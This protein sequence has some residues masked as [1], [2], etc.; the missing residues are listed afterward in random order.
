MKKVYT[1]LTSALLGAAA[2]TAAPAAIDGTARISEEGAA[3]LRS[4][5]IKMD[6]AMSVPVEGI[7]TYTRAYT[8]G[9]NQYVFSMAL[10]NTQTWADVL[11]IDKGDGTDDKVTFEEFPFYVVRTTMYIINIATGEQTAYIPQ[12]LMW[13]AKYLFSQQ[14]EEIGD[15]KIPVD[16]RDLSATSP[17][18]LCNTDQYCKKFV[19]GALVNGGMNPNPPYDEATGQYKNWLIM[20]Q[21]M[22]QVVTDE[23]NISYQGNPAV[24]ICTTSRAPAI[25]FKYYLEDVNE[26]AM[27]YECYLNVKTE[28]STVGRNVRVSNFVGSTRIDGWAPRDISYPIHELH[29]FNA[30]ETSSSIMGASSPYPMPW[31]PVRRL[32]VMGFGND[33][34]EVGYKT[35]SN[36][37]NSDDLVAQY[38][39]TVPA[40]EQVNPDNQTFFTGGLYASMDAANPYYGH[41]TIATPTYAWVP[42]ISEEFG[43]QL[44]MIPAPGVAIPAFQL[45]DEELMK[46]C[47]EHNMKYPTET[48]I[49]YDGWLMWLQTYSEIMLNGT[50]IECGT[51]EGFM[52]YG[53]DNYDNTVTAK[54]NG[55][56]FYHADPNNC[57]VYEEVPS[58][59]EL[60][61]VEN[62]S[63]SGA[64]I[65]G[66]NGAINVNSTEDA[67]V[68]IYNVNGQTVYNGAVKANATVSVELPAGLYLVKA[69]KEAKKVVL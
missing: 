6:H 38:K 62:V 19:E 68:V 13:P 11:S 43:P 26:L 63:V 52:V 45:P 22:M 18:E 35:N 64:A 10:D 12:F 24:T 56:I 30:G 47:E 1:L 59:G 48:Y 21:E 4:S 17:N 44:Q 69:G 53:K 2:A 54:F 55:N 40:E 49:K 34:F 51:T 7:D 15:D 20:N 60:E 57:Q 28:T 58:V 14:Y 31:G 61:G 25:T 41:W 46:W 9:S 66:A 27:S 39:L 67:A 8:S 33:L 32:Y 29:I 36:I 16:E 65:Y 42:G 37:F 23:A 5:I 50:H 3:K